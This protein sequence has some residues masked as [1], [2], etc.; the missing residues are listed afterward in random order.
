MVRFALTSEAGLNDPL[1][2]PFVY[3][4]LFM[5]GRGPIGDWLPQWVL[6]S[7]LGKLVVGA[8]A[9]W[10]AGLALGRMA[11]RGSERTLSVAEVGNP[12][13]ALAG[14]FVVYG[15]TEFSV[16]TASSRS[17]P[18]PSPCVRWSAVTATTGNCTS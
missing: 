1:T 12:L 17:S 5:L 13:L 11:F 4:G 15:F 18:P 10:F 9:G 8:L 3:L 6:W 7:L 14:T 16:G 2:F